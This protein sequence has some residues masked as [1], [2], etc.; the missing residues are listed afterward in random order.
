[1]LLHKE[2]IALVSLSALV[3]AGAF[4]Q[5]EVQP[6]PAVHPNPPKMQIAPRP[7]INRDVRSLLEFV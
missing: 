4:S 3:W 5:N 7:F 6:R 1:M 2:I